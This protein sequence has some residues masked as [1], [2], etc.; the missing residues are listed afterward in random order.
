MIA[1]LLQEQDDFA[2]ATYLYLNIEY[3]T[4]RLDPDAKKWCTIVTHFGKYK[5]LR[6]SMGIS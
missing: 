4:I 3:Y 6:L 2:Y 1:Q 5:Y